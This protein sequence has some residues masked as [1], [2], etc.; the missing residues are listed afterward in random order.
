MISC[1]R[2]Y[3]MC[4]FISW[5]T[6]EIFPGCVLLL[7]KK[8]IT[9][10]PVIYNF[11]MGRLLEKKFGTGRVPGSR[12]ALININIVIIAISAIIPMDMVQARCLF[13]Y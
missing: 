13:E 10:Y 5:I 8:I 6:L 12:R 2:V 3:W 4:H 1:G 7:S 11:G 9:W